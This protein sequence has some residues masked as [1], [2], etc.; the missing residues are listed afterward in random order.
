MNEN[1]RNGGIASW[2]SQDHR[3]GCR[4]IGSLAALSPR[5]FAGEDNTIRVA[6]VGCGGRARSDRQCPRD[7]ERTDQAGRD[8][9]CLRGPAATLYDGLVEAASVRGP[10]LG[11]YVV[12]GYQAAQIEV[13]PERRFIG[14][15]AYQKAMNCLR[16]GDVVILRRLW[17]SAGCTSATRSRRESTCSWRSPS[18][19][20]GPAREDPPAREESARRT[21]R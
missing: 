7:Q 16:P 11:R 14:F 3:T 1:H 4:C 12:M 19:W 21:S 5:I 6:L 10:A 20:T 2:V 17:H 13:P 18:P 9:G 15:D 8:G